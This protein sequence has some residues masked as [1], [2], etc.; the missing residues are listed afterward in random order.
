[1]K[2]WRVGTLSMACSLIL[3]GIVLFLSQI[4]GYETLDILITWWPLI[5]VLIGIEILFY[6]FISKQENSVIKYDIFSILVV[7]FIGSL[8]ILLFIFTSTGLIQ[9]VR[10]VIN[11]V[12]S[13]QELPAINQTIPEE[14]NRI[15]V[16]TNN[17]YY[18]TIQVDSTKKREL[19]LF[20]NAFIR[21]F[22]EGSELKLEDY[23]SQNIVGDTMY[24][25]FKDLPRKSGLASEY[26]H[27]NVTL[28]LPEQLK[29]EID[30]RYTDFI[31]LTESKNK[32]WNIIKN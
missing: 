19:H 21:S 25:T 27:M 13:N 11:E 28:V 1:M 17:Q 24:V 26:K 14:I 7:G 16:Q 31:M 15:I 18:T 12:E 9:E 20:G 22:D 4:W 23:F 3:L 2:Q 29:V 10:Y 6:S 32:N 30:N 5:A 8:C